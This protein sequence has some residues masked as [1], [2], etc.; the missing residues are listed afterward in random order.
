MAGSQR[1]KPGLRSGDI[2]GPREVRL[3]R[4]G[5]AVGTGAQ[6]VSRDAGEGGGR[7]GALIENIAPKDLRKSQREVWNVE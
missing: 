6:A 3:A 1:Y 5:A 4:V 7:W 2:R